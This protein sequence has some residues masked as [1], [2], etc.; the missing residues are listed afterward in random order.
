MPFRITKGKGKEITLLQRTSHLFNPI[1]HN[2][3][4]T[5]YTFCLNDRHWNATDSVREPEESNAE[6]ISEDIYNLVGILTS[7]LEAANMHGIWAYSTAVGK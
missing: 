5:K 4:L 7:A 3:F 1:S 2:S 6:P